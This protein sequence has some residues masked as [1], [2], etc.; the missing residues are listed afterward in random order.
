MTLKNRAKKALKLYFV[1]FTLISILLMIL[2][3]LFDADRPL[4]YQ[5]FLSPLIYAALG[6]IPVLLFNQ[7]KELSVK[8]LIIRRIIELVLIE[9]IYLVLA[10]SSDN[11]PTEK[12]GV[13]I[14]ISVGVAI[15]YGITI[16]IE[17]IF[18]SVESK[19][20]NEYLYSFQNRQNG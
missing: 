7:E 13:I 18:E 17:Y 12:F 6:V 9:A 8:G 15:V 2:G 4:G 5:V 20:M 10:F 11:I 16:L 1:L 19:E 14:G 3:L